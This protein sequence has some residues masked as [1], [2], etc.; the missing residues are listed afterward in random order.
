MYL[1]ENKFS[2]IGLQM[3]IN[4]VHVSEINLEFEKDIVPRE[5]FRFCI[6]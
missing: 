1:S 3:S 6:A 5:N 4:L 2:R